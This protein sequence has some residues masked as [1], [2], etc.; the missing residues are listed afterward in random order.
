MAGPALA[1]GHPHRL[2]GLADATGARGAWLVLGLRLGLRL[3]VGLVSGLGLGLGLALG[4]TLGLGLGL[5][6]DG[7]RGAEREISG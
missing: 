1:L 3:G 5:G 2:H 7:R 6:L 4:L